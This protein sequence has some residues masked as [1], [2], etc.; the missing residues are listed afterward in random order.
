MSRRRPP[1]RPARPAPSSVAA[2]RP[3]RIAP[4]APERPAPER[5]TR[6]TPYG[7]IAPTALQ[8]AEQ[9]EARRDAAGSGGSGSGAR[10]G[11]SGRGGRTPAQGGRRATPRRARPR[12]PSA[13][14]PSA[15]ATT[16]RARRQAAATGGSAAVLAGRST[17]PRGRGPASPAPPRTRGL[18]GAVAR[19]RGRRRVRLILVLYVLLTVGMAWRLVSVQVVAAE[20]YRGLASQQAERRIELPAQ[21]GKLYDRAGQPLAMSLVASTIYADPRQIAAEGANAGLLAE[22]LA[23]VLDAAGQDVDAGELREQ[24]QRDTGFTYLARQVPREVGERVAALG[25][26]G[27][28]VLEEPT[29]VYPAGSLAGSVL[30]LAGIDHTGLTGLESEYDEVLSGRPGELHIESAPGGVEISAAPREVRPPEPGTDVVLTLDRAV[31]AAAEDALAGAVEEHDADGAAAVV[32]DVDTGEVLA[33]ASVPATEDGATAQ[34]RAVVDAYEPGSVNKVITVA[35]ALEEGLAAPSELLDV[36]AQ[37]TVGDGTFSESEGHE[38]GTMTLFD[39]IVRSSNTATIELAQRLG[40]D[41]LHEYV[42]RF[43]Y[44]RPTGI[45]FPG[46]SAGILPEVSQWSQTS[47]PSIAIGYGASSSLLQVA[48]VF[49]TIASGGAWVQPSLVRGTVG[50]DGRLVPADAPE[51]RRVVSPETAEAVAEMLVGVVEDEDGTGQLGAVPGYGVGGKT[52]T[53]RKPSMTERGYEPGAYIASYAG[54]AP[55]EDPAIVVAVMVD[56]PRAG[57]IYGGVVAAPIFSRIMDFTLAHQ[58][59][60]PTRPPST[61]TGPDAAEVPVEPPPPGA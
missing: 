49:G 56:R 41:R 20:E 19:A 34:N 12:A 40:P 5:R 42:E 32:L 38:A 37:V 44:G 24:L 1:A 23:E 9:A 28:G 47:L 3:R 15:R 26:A 4:P 10:P 36:P 50:A 8:A 21:R 43:G 60:A 46:E 27:I 25:L 54:F 18:G 55:A 48:D 53:A 31:Q 59:I 58:R 45:G 30:G 7:T 2:P 57:E 6:P 35:A 17:P 29:R 22:R 13:R 16:P 39:A 52:G 51:R 33:L 14:V 61:T 11:G